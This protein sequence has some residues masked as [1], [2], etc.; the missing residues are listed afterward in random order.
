MNGGV[1]GD[2]GVDLC[3][4]VLEAGDVGCERGHVLWN[5]WIGKKRRLFVDDGFKLITRTLRYP[6]SGIDSLFVYMI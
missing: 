2:A 5:C 4:V 6:S 1:S 3:V